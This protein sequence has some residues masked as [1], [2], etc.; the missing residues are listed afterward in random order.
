MYEESLVN[1]VKRFKEDGL[2]NIF[3]EIVSLAN[4]IITTPMSTAEAERKFSCMKRIK[5]RLRS[6][7]NNTR[8]NA[9]GVLS[10]EKSLINEKVQTGKENFQE[11]VLQHFIRQKN[12]KMSF[13]LQRKKYCFI[14]LFIIYI[15][16]LFFSSHFSSYFENKFLKPP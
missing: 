13:F 12:R 16:K 14:N 9:L 4:I 8:L 7:M 11:K 6:R 5:S 2:E 1:L 15:F 3:S 10:M